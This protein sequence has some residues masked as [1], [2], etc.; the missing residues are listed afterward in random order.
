MILALQKLQ[1]LVDYNPLEKAADMW[2]PAAVLAD[3]LR[4]MAV[5][6]PEPFADFLDTL[7]GLDNDE[8]VS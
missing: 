6:L 3:A 2:G 1:S 4:E 8:H 7:P 5:E